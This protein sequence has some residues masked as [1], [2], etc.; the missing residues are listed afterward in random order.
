MDQIRDR[1]ASMAGVLQFVQHEIDDRYRRVIGARFAAFRFFLLRGFVFLD[2]LMEELLVDDR[3]RFNRNIREIVGL[4]IE[5]Q[6]PVIGPDQRIASEVAATR[7]TCC[8][9]G[10]C[11][12]CKS[13]GNTPPFSHASKRSIRSRGLDRGVTAEYISLIDAPRSQASDPRE[14]FDLEI[15]QKTYFP[16]NACATH[17][18]KPFFCN[19]SLRLF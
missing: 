2:G 8:S 5:M 9:V 10:A 15:M 3:Q 14:C 11:V 12:S 13:N 6:L 19:Q 16:I 7:R 4:K 18:S 17:K 1:R